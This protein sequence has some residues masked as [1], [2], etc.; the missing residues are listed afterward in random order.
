MERYLVEV[1]MEV[2]A[3]ILFLEAVLALLPVSQEVLV[4]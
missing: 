1:V 4:L 2:L 3:V